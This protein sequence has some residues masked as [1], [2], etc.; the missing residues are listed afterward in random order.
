MRTLIRFDFIGVSLP[1]LCLFVFLFDVDF[2]IVS[3]GIFPFKKK[4]R[5][6]MI[7]DYVHVR[8]LLFVHVYG[9]VSVLKE[10]FASSDLQKL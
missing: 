2:E 4:I 3:M 6:S 1:L 8:T 9:F 7:F 10:P 5:K